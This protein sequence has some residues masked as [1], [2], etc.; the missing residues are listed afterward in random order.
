MGTPVEIF[1][2]YEER[3]QAMKVQMD[4]CMQDDSS[5]RKGD[6]CKAPPKIQATKATKPAQAA[7]EKY[8]KKTPK[9]ATP[10]PAANPAAKTGKGKL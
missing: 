1:T 2:K 5:W 7:Y 3:A 4:K 8:G 9:K 6:P 10:N